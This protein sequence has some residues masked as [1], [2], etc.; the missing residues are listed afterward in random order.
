[1]VYNIYYLILGLNSSQIKLK[2]DCRAI[3]Y[4]KMGYF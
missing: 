4:I 1:M 2:Y 3:H